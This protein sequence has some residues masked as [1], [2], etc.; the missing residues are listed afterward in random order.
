MSNLQNKQSVL[1]ENPIEID[2]AIEYMRMS[3][4]GMEWMTNAYHI[5]NKFIRKEGQMKFYYPETYVGYSNG[6]YKYHRLTPDNDYKGMVFFIITDENIDDNLM[7]F[8]VSAIFSANLKLIDDT[9]LKTGNFKQKLIRDA[10]QKL[11]NL[12]YEIDFDIKINK[13]H[14]KLQDVYREFSLDE[15]ENYNRLPLQVFRFDMTVTIPEDCDL[16]E[17]SGICDNC[18]C[19]ECEFIIIH[20]S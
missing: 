9:I 17:D 11:E 15:L 18:P 5:A 12:K 1:Y 6:K 8:E 14:R 4:S 19:D 7:T 16:Y 20:N 13:V 10:R 3:L 2:K